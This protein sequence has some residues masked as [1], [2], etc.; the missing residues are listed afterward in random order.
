[1]ISAKHLEQLCLYKT[2]WNIRLVLSI[3]KFRIINSDEYSL[4]IKA[5]NM[6][7]SMITNLLINANN[8]SSLGKYNLG[9]RKVQPA[10]CKAEE[11][12]EDYVQGRLS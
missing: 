12:R 9:F 6:D 2:R 4:L 1:M 8:K 3:D 10:K 11:R 5:E 7:F